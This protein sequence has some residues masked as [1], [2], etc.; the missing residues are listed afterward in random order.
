MLQLLVDVAQGSSP[1]DWGD[2]N[3][4]AN[5]GSPTCVS[6]WRNVRP[7]MRKKMF[8]VFHESGIFIAACRHCFV[9]LACDMIQSGEL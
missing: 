4:K 1:D 5:P 7:E 6:R 8:L 2:E 3:I 9:L